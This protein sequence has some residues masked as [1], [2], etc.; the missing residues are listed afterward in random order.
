M[1]VTMSWFRRGNVRH[2][3]KEQG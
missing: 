1:E 2:L 3:R